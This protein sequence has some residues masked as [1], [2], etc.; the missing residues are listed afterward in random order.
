MSILTTKFDGKNYKIR[1]SKGQPISIPVRPRAADQLRAFGTEHDATATLIGGGIKGGEVKFNCDVIKF[2]PHLNGTHTEGPGH[3]LNPQLPFSS[4]LARSM[5]HYFF[6]AVLVTVDPEDGLSSR[7]SYTPEWEDGDQA[8]TQRA[9]T[10]AFNKINTGSPK[11]DHV[12][13]CI[14]RTKPNDDF[15]MTRDYTEEPSAF[16]SSDAMDFLAEKLFLQHLLVDTISVDRA[17][18]EGILRNHHRWWNVRQRS[19]ITG[20]NLR[21]DRTI[22]ELIYVSPEVQDGFCFVNIQ[23]GNFEGTD[24]VPSTVTL[25][26]PEP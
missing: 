16:L 3:I 4:S 7:E 20:M 23:P 1:L 26:K 5:S 12:S 25:F 15:K 24:A 11:F 8:I 14:I 17:A 18:D 2:A 9:L 21:D 19:H 6:P 10:E 22:T 13:A